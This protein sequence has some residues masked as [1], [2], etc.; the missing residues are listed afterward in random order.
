[1]AWNDD[2]NKRDPWSQRGDQGPP[3]LDDTFRKFQQT[4]NSWFGGGGRGGSGSS[5]G[6]G[7]KKFLSTPLIL[8]ALGVIVLVYAA[9]GIYQVDAQERGVVFRFGKVLDETVG[10]GLHWNPPIMDKVSIVNVTQVRSSSHEGQMLTEDENIVGINLVVQYV[11]NDPVKHLVDIRSPEESLRHATESAL[12]HVVGSSTMDAVITEGRA[13]LGIEVQ[14]RLQTYVN[15]Y[16]TGYRIV[17]VNIDSVGPPAE[18]QDAFDDVQKAKE[19][20]VRIINQANA[21]AEQVVPEARGAAQMAIEEANAYR[22]RAVARAEGEAERFNKL[23]KEYSAAPDITR[24]R[25]YIETL[26]EVL[27]N[28][29]LIMV[30]VDEGNNLLYLPLDQLRRQQPVLSGSTALTDASRTSSNTLNNS[31][32]TGRTGSSV[33]R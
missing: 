29:G 5:G 24:V 26:E 8:I 11:V 15:R 33:G 3:D 10:P 9:F 32:Q 6:G 20:E 31:S 22:D 2:N 13:I 23:L 4:I 14:D 1:M 16:E 18:V 7:G 19:D 12:R 27:S 25:L 21:Y 28:V 17:K 30:D